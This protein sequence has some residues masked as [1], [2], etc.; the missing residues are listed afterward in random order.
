MKIA[1]MRRRMSARSRWLSGVAAGVDMLMAGLS[2]CGN[3]RRQGM[4]QAA[5]WFP[6]GCRAEA[7]PCGRRRPRAALLRGDAEALDQRAPLAGFA[8]HHLAELFRRR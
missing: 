1:L 8:A 3:R 2:A 6:L 7:P 5:N 4:E